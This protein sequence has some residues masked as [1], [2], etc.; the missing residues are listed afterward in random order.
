SPVRQEI[1][2]TLEAMGGE[3]SVAELAAEIGRPADGLYYH[4]RL[5]ARGGVLDEVAG[6]GDGRRYRSRAREFTR[7][8]YRPGATANA[9]A[10]ERVAAALLRIAGRDFAAAIARRDVVVEGERRELWAS[11][12]KGWVGDSELAEINRLL[13]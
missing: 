12:V 11:R 3:A 1:V 5:L 8:V 10:V 9:A 2:D 7:L 6:D 4:L 13:E